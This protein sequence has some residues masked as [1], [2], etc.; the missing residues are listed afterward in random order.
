MKK[1]WLKKSS[2]ILLSLTMV[3]SLFPGMN[4]TIP[5]VLAAENT[6]PESAY[7]TDVSG[8]K[9][10]S[11]DET[12]DTEGR[13][14]FGQNGSGAAQQWKIAGI[15]SG[16]NGDNIILFAASPLGSSAFQKEYN[17]NK[18]YDPNWNC[19][20]P[21]GTTVSEV[22]P[23]H[24]GVSDLRAEL[25]TYMRDN[26]YFSES[27]KTKMN[28]TTIYTDDKNNST[29]YSVTDILY[30]PY[31]DYYRPNDKYVT[32]GTN[33]SDKLN[34][35]VMINISK[36]GNDIF[37]LRS[38]SDTFKSKALVVCPG[39]SVCA[40]NVEDINSLVPAFDLN[41]S[42]VSFASAAEA[43]SSS[44]S[45]FKA[46]DT[47]NTMTAN[48]Y[49]LR[50]KSSGNEEAVIS[51]NGT[52][53]N[54]KNANEKYLMVQNNNG[55]YAL[56]IDSDNQTINASDIQMGSAESDKLA[57]FNNCKVWLES[58]NADRITTAK[59]AVTTIN[60]IEITDITA[61][62]AGS[63][64][65]TE[66]ACATTGVS[67]TTPT[68]T[69]IHG[70][71]SVTGNAGYNTKY[72]AS[73]TLTAK[74]GYEFAS[75]V[76]AT[77]DGK[78][79]SVTKN[80]NGITVSYSYKK[81]APK[82]VSNDYFATVD[83]LKDCYNIGDG[84]IGKIRFGLNGSDSRLWAICGKDGSNLALLSTSAFE[85]TTYG[86]TSKY[87]TSNFVTEMNKYLTSEYFSKEEKTKMADV[88]VK[89]N[90]PNVNSGNEEKTVTDKKLYLP[91]SQDQNSHG[92]KTIYVG[93]SNDIAIDVTSDV[94]LRN[95]FWLR[96]PNK[97][98]SN[99]ALVAL[100]LTEVDD[101]Y[102]QNKCSVV[103]AFDLNLSDVSFASAAEAATS[104]G[105]KANSD[106]TANTYTL[107]YAS[108]GNEEAVISPN[109]TKIEVTG[110]SGKYLMVQNSTGV[111]AMKIDSNNQ[112]INASDIQM[113]SSALDNFN[114]CKVWLES[115]DAGRI[116]T[117]KMATQATVTTINSIEITDIT[118]P[119]AGS[120]FDTEAACTTIGVSTKTPT[121][122]WTPND[123][124]A[125]YNTT[126]TASVTLTAEAGYEFASNVTATMDG[127]TA[128]VTK[129]QDGGI[130]V[131]Y[132]Y[133]KTAPKAVSNAYFATVDDLKDCYNISDGKTIGKIKFGLN[134]SDARLWAIC[135]KDGNNL[136]LLSTSEFAK[137]AYG[138]TSAYSTSNFV[139]GMDKYLTLDYFSIEEKTK[140]ADVTVKTNEPKGKGG[141]E[142]KTVTNKLYLPNSKDQKSNGQT[143]IYVGSSN[144]IAIDVTKL[145]D[146]GLG[147]LFWLRSPYD[148]I[149]YYVLLAQPGKD[150]HIGSVNGGDT[151]VVPAFNLNLSDVS[152]ASAAEAATSTGY[153]AN[154]EMTANTYT[155]RYE[156]SGSETA[157]V[158]AAGSQV[159]ITNAT[160]NM[161]LVV[162]NS[163][164]A[165]TKELTSSTTSVSA[166][167]IEGLDNFNNCKV[168]L[169]STDEY[170]ITTAMM[171]T[172]ETADVTIT[173]AS[174]MT[175]TSES[176][177]E[178][179]TGI[180]GAMKDVV[181]EANSGY[182]FP[183][184]YVST[185]SGLTDGAINGIKVTRDSLTQIT[186]SGA[187]TAKSTTIALAD[188]MKKEAASTP[189]IEIDY[190]NETL[191]GFDTATEYSINDGAAFTPTLSTIP[192][193]DSYYGNTIKIKKTET[194]TAL[195]SAEQSL[196]IPA[197]PAAPAVTGTD[198]TVDGKNDG[199]I[200]GVDDTME[201]S[202]SMNGPW[203]AC[204][205]D[206][207]DGTISK[208]GV[209]TYYVR[210]AA[211]TTSF[212]GEITTVTIGKGVPVKKV[213]S[214]T[215][216]TF[217]TVT[218]GYTRPEAKKITI[219]N[220]TAGGS[221]WEATVSDVTLTGTDADKFEVMGS[222]YDWTIQPKSDLTANTD[223][224][225]KTYTAII[226]V[227]YDATEGVTS[228]AI[229][230]VSF[231]VNP[232]SNTVTVTS[233][234]LDNGSTTGN[235]NKGATVTVKADSTPSGYK[236]AGWTGTDGLTLLDGT[237]STSETIKFTM[238]EEAVNITATYK[239]I[240]APSATIH[241]KTNTWNSILNKITFG[242]FFKN[243][244][245]VTITGTDN[246]SGVDKI[247]YILSEKE[248]SE[249]IQI[250]FQ[251]IQVAS[252]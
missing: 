41:L 227:A 127:K 198:E 205:R 15:D 104:I 206:A 38:P 154:S 128:S 190:V 106:M 157:V 18:P 109:G 166:S 213:L 223:G 143:T 144:D 244:Q 181:Y 108:A 46:N 238:P 6:S 185:I 149:S 76:K 175:K 107:R 93:N 141:N 177:A 22:F 19:T 11:L 208:L 67:T 165:Y 20:Y 92:Q 47:D 151:S 150:V 243:T 68:V 60:S 171:A 234:T 63:A 230:E 217:D 231:T 129:N 218:E 179:Q 94:G 249:V 224:T 237:T 74:A 137:A 194:D 155:L 138:D 28:Q 3:L 146:V 158:N 131:S 36:W 173:P 250:N 201:Y 209:G 124:T 240:A 37:W 245:D 9:S 44:Y 88:T 14:I 136:A 83:D 130:T 164:G 102:V 33:T 210:K 80:Q 126:Y 49:T 241:V 24:Y 97:G 61:P 222:G 90:E 252:M 189:T 163:A 216:P 113:G 32:V 100:P 86:N 89:T 118:S 53:I 10:F 30:A 23:N 34:G 72:T 79:A 242:H 139:T 212:V 2:A 200:T 156:S 153:K 145:N 120:A 52:E 119:V 232:K 152:F 204:I 39:Q 31:G 248:L 172:Q 16:I 84:T 26:S 58:T 196:D 4:G 12:S 247:E 135:G 125:G 214:V 215:A 246:E 54:V 105:Y 99:K 87:S 207:V 111:Y 110:A 73:V 42:D 182:Y 221:N 174:N 169:E 219:K 21:D 115:T 236:F 183:D 95:H 203:T 78:A 45:G 17:T 159:A 62:V 69:W 70:G 7:W 91:N 114:N 192:I 187:P 148:D 117:A 184:D 59:M 202:M 170:R 239:D 51:L 50:Y 233:G 123:T 161:Y 96:S 5:T 35:G 186:V 168:W 162:Q 167:D 147:N 101:N 81:T 229:A 211:T 85:Y 225:A 25:N 13:I 75:N 27:E 65:D 191:T 235:F 122:T 188:P 160:D 8:L 199:T 56:K 251:S 193:D 1:K 116:T 220:D 121:V 43:A 77:I 112:I 226:N 40:D 178:N 176:G 142:E 103:P 29:T 55:V 195:A 140:M 82:A 64:F 57:N 197:R 98:Y 71:E 180:T 48:T 134:G 66:A 133:K 132:S 228:P